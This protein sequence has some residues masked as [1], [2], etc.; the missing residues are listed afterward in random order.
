MLDLRPVLFVVGLLICPVGLAMV[1]PATMK[2]GKQ[3]A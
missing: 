2:P 1:V 3:N